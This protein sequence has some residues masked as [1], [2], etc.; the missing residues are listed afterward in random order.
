MTRSLRLLKHMA[1][2]Q[3]LESHN[4]PWHHLQPQLW[5][6]FSSLVQE[7]HAENH[8]TEATKLVEGQYSTDKKD[9]L[10]RLLPRSQ[11]R[12]FKPRRPNCTSRS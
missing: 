1:G 8:I 6:Q 7:G 2:S 9:S 11:L 3:R 5:D 4:Q 10:G 12:D